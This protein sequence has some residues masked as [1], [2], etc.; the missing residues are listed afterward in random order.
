[1]PAYLQFA[2]SAARDLARPSSGMP[3]CWHAKRGMRTTLRGVCVAFDRTH[4]DQRAELVMGGNRLTVSCK[5]TCTGCLRGVPLPKRRAAPQGK[6]EKLGTLFRRRVRVCSA[7]IQLLDAL[8]NGENR[9]VQRDLSATHDE[10]SRP[11]PTVA[12]GP[13][14]AQLRG[15]MLA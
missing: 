11:R 6:E 5:G 9:N 15:L 2:V 4:S 7:R 3:Y 14:R 12:F 8:M 1:M 10:N 13:S